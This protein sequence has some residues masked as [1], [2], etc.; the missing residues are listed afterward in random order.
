M[1]KLFNIYNKNQKRIIQKYFLKYYYI[2]IK[3]KYNTKSKFKLIPK[4]SYNN[5][6]Q[7]KKKN[8]IKELE[9]KFIQ[10]SIN[11]CT[12]SPAI[13]KY[14]PN[15]NK[16]CYYVKKE[17]NNSNKNNIYDH[18]NNTA[19][20]Q[21]FPKPPLNKRK[22]NGK[23]MNQ[24]LSMKFDNNIFNGEEKIDGII[25]CKYN[26]TNCNTSN[27]N[28]LNRNNI[29]DNI[30]KTFHKK[31]LTSSISLKNYNYSS[32]ISQNNSN[33]KQNKAKA[34]LLI[35]E[36]ESDKLISEKNNNYQQQYLHLNK[37]NGNISQFQNIGI[38]NPILTNNKN[39][40][41]SNINH[42]NYSSPSNHIVSLIKTTPKLK[43]KI[44]CNTN[45][46]NNYINENK[47][48]IFANKYRRNISYNNSIKSKKYKSFV[49]NNDFNLPDQKFIPLT[50][51]KKIK[52]IPRIKNKSLDF[53]TKKH[54]LNGL[55]NVN[56]SIDDSKV[57]V[58]LNT[59]GSI[60]KNDKIEYYYN[61]NSNDSLSMNNNLINNKS[62]P[63]YINTISTKSTNNI[64]TPIESVYNSKKKS[65]NQKSK[66]NKII[67]DINKNNTNYNDKAIKINENILLNKNNKYN[68]N[69]GNF[70]NN[71][72]NKLV[73]IKQKGI[74]NNI[75][76]Y[77]KNIEGSL[78]IEKESLNFSNY[79]TINLLTGLSSKR[80][81]VQS[82]ISI[83]GTKF[84]F[85]EN[86]KKKF[87]L[88]VDSNVISECL[89]G[90]VQGSK[91]SS[92]N[93]TL[94]SINDSKMYEIAGCYMNNDECKI[95]EK[96]H[97]KNILSEKYKKGNI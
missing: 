90:T 79:N 89:E 59:N 76:K 18:R 36:N 27:K 48:Q 30:G 7:N 92:E 52:N 12:F 58:N 73:N 96:Y 28:N 84:N 38:N 55:L 34:Y 20:Y 43:L 33:Q 8:V 46:N 80:K 9:E 13:N 57:T 94:Q 35:I 17:I 87:S 40:N 44:P 22:S 50:K 54:T 26:L 78:S 29:Y 81:N 1:K 31:N 88:K 45:K 21:M 68:I 10:N 95:K 56:T 16:T 85:N 6:I 72:K 14:P 41:N 93:V 49:K 67:R 62:H 37:L 51:P 15:F 63:K 32:L 97:I 83:S 19:F 53:S 4:R 47:R 71:I 23:N 42:L 3:L 69:N 25:N 66:I 60:S 86:Q 82:N 5:F 74:F 70:K 64:I 91:K 75:S 2:T 77:K 11:E 65:E 61:N 39:K 24:N